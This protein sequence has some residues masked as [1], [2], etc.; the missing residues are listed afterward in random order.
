MST[1]RAGFVAACSALGAGAAHAA[2]AAA[3][4]DLEQRWG[5]PERG[6]HDLEHLDEVLLH[7][8]LLGVMSAPT[9]LAAW[10]HDAVYT[11]RSE[12]HGSSSDEHVTPSDEQASADLAVLVLIDVGAP[13]S[14]A[15]RVAEL[16]RVTERHEPG[17]G[18]AEAAALCDADLA[19]LASGPERYARY[20]EGV[21]REYCFLDD[22]SFV[23]GRAAVLRR[24]LARA[25]HDTHPDG[26][27]FSTRAGHRLWAD[28]ALFNLRA[29]LLHLNSGGCV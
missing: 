5:G 15:A 2:L 24:L 25:E 19:V 3:A 1:R 28:R 29:E 18:D 22:I 23:A 26:P 12:G 11:G 7:L 14:S 17:A 27:L 9:V 8:E 4:A 16:V 20:T 10:F 6:Y 21:R 13:A